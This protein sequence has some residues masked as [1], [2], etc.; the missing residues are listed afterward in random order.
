MITGLV[1]VVA[2]EVLEFTVLNAVARRVRHR[3]ARGR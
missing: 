3:W 2:L 1:I